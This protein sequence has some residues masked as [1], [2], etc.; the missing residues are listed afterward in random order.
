MQ[1]VTVNEKSFPS[2]FENEPQQSKTRNVSRLL[3]HRDWVLASRKRQMSTKADAQPWGL[4]RI[5]R[6][7]YLWTWLFKKVLRAHI[8]AEVF[9]F[10]Q[11]IKGFFGDETVL[12]VRRAGY[13]G[14]RPPSPT[15]QEATPGEYPATDKIPS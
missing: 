3:S 14:L 13:Y 2:I 15:R 1:K 6:E 4:W 8:V 9:K 10:A 5:H 11:V 7:P 12:R